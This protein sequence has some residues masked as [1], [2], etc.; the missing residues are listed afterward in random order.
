MVGGYNQIIVESEH[1]VPVGITVGNGVVN[2]YVVGD[3]ALSH[4][5]VGKVVG[6]ASIEFTHATIAT[7]EMHES[8]VAH[9]PVEVGHGLAIEFECSNVAKGVNIKLG[10]ILG[11]TGRLGAVDVKAQC[12]PDVT[13]A[14]DSDA[15]RVLVER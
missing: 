13:A 15:C 10:L 5:L 1:L 11:N 7:V 4:H 2:E 8:I 12:Q 3:D 9:A 14:I 6:D